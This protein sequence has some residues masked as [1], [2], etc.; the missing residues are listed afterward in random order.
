MICDYSL[1]WS[2]TFMAG[3]ALSDPSFRPSGKN[4]LICHTRCLSRYRNNRNGSISWFLTQK[5]GYCT[6]PHNSWVWFAVPWI[7]H[8]TEIPLFPKS[9]THLPF[10]SFP[11]FVNNTVFPLVLSGMKEPS[12]WRKRW[13]GIQPAP[14]SSTSA[15][16]FLLL[17]FRPLC[18]YSFLY[19]V[20]SSASI[21]SMHLSF[22]LNLFSPLH[23]FSSHPLSFHSCIFNSG[24]LIS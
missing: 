9:V 18:I 15:N 5:A 12:M 10:L 19:S 1:L 23:L 21:L 7:S 11:T 13:R 8:G 22:R 20:L 17:I 16:L 2:D 24:L 4:W 3:V 14:P 6:N